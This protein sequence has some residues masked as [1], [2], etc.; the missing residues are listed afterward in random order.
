MK[1][2]FWARDEVLYQYGFIEL[3]WLYR[4]W[5]NII[6]CRAVSIKTG[7]SNILSRLDVTVKWDAWTVFKYLLILFQNGRTTDR[8]T[9]LNVEVPAYKYAAPKN[10]N[11]FLIWGRYGHQKKGKNHGDFVFFVYFILFWYFSHICPFYF[12]IVLFPF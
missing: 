2:P 9:T 12:K 4:E 1:L 10:E 7:R 8:M 5:S 11:I 3:Y 6:T